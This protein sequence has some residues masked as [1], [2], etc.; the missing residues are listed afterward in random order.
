MK[1]AGFSSI[2]STALLCFVFWLLITGELAALFKGEPSVQILIA[3]AAVSIL[4]ALFSARF[5]I[6]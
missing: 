6:H 5:F 1:K 4:V 3:G 2:A